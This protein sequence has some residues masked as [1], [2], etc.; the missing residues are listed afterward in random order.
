MGRWTEQQLD[1]A[2]DLMMAALD[3]ECSPAERESLEQ[4]LAENAELKS[5]WQELSQVKEA[6]QMVNFRNPP[7]EVWQNYWTGVYA[8]LERGVAW[9]LISLGAIVLLAWGAWEVVM[10]LLADTDTPGFIKLAVGALAIGGVIL[11]VSVVREKLFVRR[12]DPYKDIE[13]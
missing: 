1:Q 8:R 12:A 4:M 9:V 6:T 11:F 3:G 10:E 2:R 5:E 13:R 7:E